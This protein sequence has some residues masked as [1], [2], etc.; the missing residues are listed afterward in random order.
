[1]DIWNRFQ[2]LAKAT[3]QVLKDSSKIFQNPVKLALSV[4][5]VDLARVDEVFSNEEH[6]FIQ[7]R[8]CEYFSISKDQAYSLIEKASKIVEENI[9][10]EKFAEMLKNNL[11]PVEREEIITIMR[12]LIVADSEVNPLEKN[13]LQRYKNLLGVEQ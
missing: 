6:Y 4:M 13:L 2:H 7:E 1:M 12:S 8:L 5:L 10:Q 9:E 3:G 11:T